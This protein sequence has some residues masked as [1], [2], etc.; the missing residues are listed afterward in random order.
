MTYGI[1]PHL[2]VGFSFRLLR[3]WSIDEH[4]FLMPRDETVDRVRCVRSWRW[5]C[6]S[7]RTQDPSG[8]VESLGSVCPS[9]EGLRA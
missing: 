8:A 2:P 6:P 5:L 7:A 1:V 3:I 4:I 9:P